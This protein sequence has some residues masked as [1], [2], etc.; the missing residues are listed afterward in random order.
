LA[1]NIRI[2]ETFNDALQNDGSTS[3]ENHEDTSELLQ[4]YATMVAAYNSNAA[5]LLDK[6]QGTAQ[7]LADT[8][9]LKHQQIA[10]RVSETRS[11]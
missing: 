11:H 1:H 7:L 4:N 5:Y 6:V 9:N 8:L 10:Q 2:L 3:N